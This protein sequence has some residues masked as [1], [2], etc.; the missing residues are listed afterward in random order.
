V[1]DKYHILKGR[2]W[3][4]KPIKTHPRNINIG[5]A[6]LFWSPTLAALVGHQTGFRNPIRLVKLFLKNKYHLNH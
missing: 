5:D 2:F 4:K 1:I 6:R 3:A